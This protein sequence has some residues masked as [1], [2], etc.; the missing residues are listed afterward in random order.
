MRE[1]KH[2]RSTKISL[3][4]TE[5]C[6]R[7]STESLLLMSEDR[8]VLG[9]DKATFAIEIFGHGVPRCGLKLIG[10]KYEIAGLKAENVFQLA[11]GVGSFAKLISNGF[12]L[13]KRSMTNFLARLF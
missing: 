11:P 2:Y 13:L 10:R 1:G 8:I 5:E 3:E 7:V 12:A 6:A 9:D 4:P